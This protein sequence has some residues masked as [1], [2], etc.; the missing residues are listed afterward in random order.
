MMLVMCIEANKRGRRIGHCMGIVRVPVSRVPRAHDFR[1][2]AKVG[3]LIDGGNITPSLFPWSCAS[4]GSLVVA[5]EAEA[6]G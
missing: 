1:R 6:V 4:S 3:K 2:W 5:I